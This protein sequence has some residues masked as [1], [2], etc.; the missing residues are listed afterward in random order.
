MATQRYYLCRRCQQK[1]HAGKLFQA[2]SNFSSQAPICN[3]CRE[4]RELH[5]IFSWGLE[6]GSVDHRV[7]HVFVPESCV[8]WDGENGREITFHPFLVVM[9]RD[10]EGGH[11]FWLPYWHI[12]NTDGRIETKYGQWAPC[13]EDEQFQSLIAQAHAK[14]Y[15]E[16]VVRMSPKN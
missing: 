12:V 14:G 4:T 16:S 8:K 7:L 11:S 15:L 6:A 2:L 13:M 5:L 9:Q 10:G 3:T 1:A